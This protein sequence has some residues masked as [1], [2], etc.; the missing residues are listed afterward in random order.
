MNRKE[1]ERE[2]KKEKNCGY[3]YCY[4][5]DMVYMFCFKLFVCV[6]RIM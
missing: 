1:R 3:K 4:R 2:G 6:F 5:N